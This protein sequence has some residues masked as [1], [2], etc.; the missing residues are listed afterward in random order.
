ELEPTCVELAPFVE[1]LAVAGP[2]QPRLHRVAAGVRRP[3]G[4]AGDPE[5]EAGGDLLAQ[6]GE[7]GRDVAG[8]GDRRV[9]LDPGEAGPR[10]DE[11]G[12]IGGGAAPAD[13]PP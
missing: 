5:A 4:R 11:H 6:R 7:R 13:T 1:G 12:L 3:V 8:P 10:E 9:A 2:C